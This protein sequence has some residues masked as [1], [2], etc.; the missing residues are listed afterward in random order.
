MLDQHFYGMTMTIQHSMG[1]FPSFTG[2]PCPNRP[3]D[4][5]N[6]KGLYTPSEKRAC[7]S[8]SDCTNVE[9]FQRY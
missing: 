5:H 7:N 3:R 1:M 4:L 8:H 2:I 6:S 9:I